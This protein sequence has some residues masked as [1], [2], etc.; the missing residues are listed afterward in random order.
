[1]KAGYRQCEASWMLEDNV[2]VLRPL[3]VFGGRKYKTYRIYE[4]PV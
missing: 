2:M 3:E 1:M 4:R